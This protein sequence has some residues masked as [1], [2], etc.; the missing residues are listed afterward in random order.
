MS[1]VSVKNVIYVSERKFSTAISLSGGS[2]RV[3]VSACS[4]MGAHGGRL[5]RQQWVDEFTTSCN[6]QVMNVRIVATT[7]EHVSIYSVYYTVCIIQCEPTLGGCS[8]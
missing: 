4:V 8:T 6:V 1:G 3:G 5:S 2:R 7:F